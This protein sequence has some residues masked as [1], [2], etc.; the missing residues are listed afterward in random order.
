MNLFKTAVLTAIFLAGIV[1][2]APAAPGSYDFRMHD[3]DSNG[4]EL[5]SVSFRVEN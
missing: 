1:F 3:T 2:T 5:T 4:R